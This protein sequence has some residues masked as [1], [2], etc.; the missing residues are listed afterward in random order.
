MEFLEGTPL[1]D[2]I[3]KEG[4]IGVERSIKLIAQACDAL[5]HAHKQGVVH[6]DLKPSNIVLTQYDEEKDYVKV[7]DFGVAKLIEVGNNGEGQKTYAGW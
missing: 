2:L 5:D 6:R 3:K 7:V 4:Q 1:S